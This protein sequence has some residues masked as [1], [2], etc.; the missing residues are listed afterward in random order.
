MGPG[1]LPTLTF[2]NSKNKGSF[3]E[4]SYEL[5]Q[6][7]GSFVADQKQGKDPSIRGP[8]GK[9]TDFGFIASLNFRAQ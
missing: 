9:D 8:A 2:C 5:P 7:L 1:S 3:W 6:A 4:K